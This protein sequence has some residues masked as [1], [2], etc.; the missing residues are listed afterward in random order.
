MGKT[1]G[2]YLGRWI[3][4]LIMICFLIPN[5]V[6]AQDTGEDIK[7]RLDALE[8]KNLELEQKL[9]DRQAA[10]STEG[11]TT[12]P[13]GTD[14]KSVEKIVNDVLKTKDEEKKKKDEEKKKAD[15]AKKAADEAETKAKGYEVGSDLSFPTARW[16]PSG[17]IFESKNGDFVNHVGG[18]IEWDNVNW[19]QPWFL[20]GTPAGGSRGAAQNANGIQAP[21][22][23]RGNPYIGGNIANLPPPPNPF[24]NTTGVGV[25]DDGEFFRRLRLRID[26][27]MYEN[28]EYHF[29]IDFANVNSLIYDQMWGGVRDIP[30]IGSVRLGQSK[31]PMGLE[32]IGSTNFLVMMERSG[33]FDSFWQEFAA[34]LW[35]GNSV[36]DQRMTWAYQWARPQNFLVGNPVN[37]GDGVSMNTGRVTFLPLY[38]DDGRSLIHLGLSAQHRT[39]D[40]GNYQDNDTLAGVTDLTTS[41]PNNNIKFIRFRS[42]YALRDAVG[43]AQGGSTLNAIQNI[44]PGDGARPIDTGTLLAPKGTN[45]IASEFMA[46]CGPFWIQA[47]ANLANT[48]D[49]QYAA[50]YTYNRNTGA[51]AVATA[52]AGY[53]RPAGQTLNYWGYYVQAGYFLTGENRGYDR[54]YGIY[55]RV[56]PFEN[57]FFTRDQEGRPSYGLGAWEVLYRYDFTDLDSKGINGGRL[58]QNTIGVNWHLNSHMKI[59]MNVLL[60]N[61]N[62]NTLIP[63]FA[64]QVVGNGQAPAPSL[65]YSNVRSG[66][67]EGLGIR[68]HIDY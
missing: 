15:D 20:Q 41:Y 14:K 27:R 40:V 51:I 44:A 60:A 53:V 6:K 10:V 43:Q 45:N 52:P 38:M 9:K 29:E 65:I 8:K 17:L 12:K 22:V 32:S 24:P 26:G 42:R 64:N 13:D 49:S 16:G 35:T 58:G 50:Y 68:M 61:N 4:G 47:E 63:N 59:M 30:Y 3:L 56:R 55:E 21:N 66:Q 18:R 54:R 7:A 48:P 57:F 5:F 25:L 33:L 46:Y 34:G 11:S 28:F 31:V 19:H 23:F 36:L 39:G 1:L 62:Y 37:F 67:V 2:R